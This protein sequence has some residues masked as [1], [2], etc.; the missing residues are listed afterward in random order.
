MFM[1]L[2]QVKVKPEES[3]RLQKFYGET[4]IPVLE[5]TAGCTFA[6]FLQSVQRGDEFLSM[7]FW[8][9]PENAHR[10]EQE[11][12]PKLLEQARPYLAESSEWRVQLT[13]ELK[14]EY[15]PVPEEPTVTSYNV[16]V[17]SGGTPFK[18][19]AVSLYLRIVSMKV[20]PAAKETMRS[21]YAREIMP[22][23]L[24]TPGCRYA[25][26][27]ENTKEGDE[28]ISVSLWDSKHAADEYERSG[29]FQSLLGRLRPMLSD[30]YQWKMGLT[31]Q[32]K[33]TTATSED[34]TVQGYRVVLGKGFS[35]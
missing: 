27:V 12:F 35:G 16:A 21:L 14:V 17:S 29:Q 8:D 10:Y 4:V 25:T 3:A 31:Q 26:L 33:S 2:L 7:T 30:L 11:T 34:T 15:Q 22:A 32:Q 9:T 1:R 5:K 18:H 24:A 23:M 20:R 6:C 19:E 13:K 28:A